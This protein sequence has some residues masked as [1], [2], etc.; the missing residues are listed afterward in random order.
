MDSANKDE[1]GG[2]AEQWHFDDA[3]CCG[4]QCFNLDVGGHATFLSLGSTE[5]FDLLIN[6][7]VCLGLELLSNQWY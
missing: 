7:L 6:T 3:S 1:G 2:I 5:F 4:S